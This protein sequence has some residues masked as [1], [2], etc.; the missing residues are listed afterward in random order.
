MLLVGALVSVLAALW[1]AMRGPNRGLYAA[2][3]AAGVAWAV[4]AGADW[5]WEMPAVSV[6]FFAAGGLAVAGRRPKRRAAETTTREL[7]MRV[8]LAVALLVGAIAPALIMLSQARLNRAATAFEVRDCGQAR[9]SAVS[10]L[11]AIAK[12]PE[13]YQLLAYCDIASVAGPQAI[14]A[15][16]EAVALEPDSWE[17]RYSLAL[18]RASDGQD[19]RQALNEASRRAPLEPL[20]QNARDAFAGKASGGDWQEAAKPLIGETLNSGRLTLR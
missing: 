14:Q 15:T 11:R 19:P 2:L 7:P 17:Y 13:P 1:V 20:V 18:A 9:D 6:F 16:E 8:G 12:R 5:D 3:F 10:S 4:R